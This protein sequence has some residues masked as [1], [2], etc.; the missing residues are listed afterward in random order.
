MRLHALTCLLFV[1]FSGARVHAQ[2]MGAELD[3]TAGYSGEEIGAAASQLRLFGEAP[4]GIRFLAEAA[5]G[6]RWAGDAPVVGE[7]LSG[8]DP[9]GG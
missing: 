5:W 9:I 2:T 8:V 4:K 7:G 1:A 6:E 3:L